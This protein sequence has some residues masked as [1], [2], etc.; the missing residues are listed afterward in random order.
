[1]AGNTFENWKPGDLV[2]TVFPW[3]ELYDM[4]R[5]DINLD[6]LDECKVVQLR[7]CM[8]QRGHVSQ[9]GKPFMVMQFADEA[10][11]EEFFGRY[12]RPGDSTFESPQCHLST[13]KKEIVERACA[14]ITE[15]R[16][17]LNAAI[18][19]LIEQVDW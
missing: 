3:P 11:G 12:G 2:W 16:D 15:V 5:G 13:D 19:N 18:T 8:K 7:V 6:G 10:D 14:G 9:D 4:C 17:E 1:M